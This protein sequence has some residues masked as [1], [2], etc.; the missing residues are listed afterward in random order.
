MSYPW[1]VEHPHDVLFWCPGYQGRL[2]W[3]ARQ[4]HDVTAGDVLTSSRNLTEIVCKQQRGAARRPDVCRR[5]ANVPPRVAALRRNARACSQRYLAADPK[6][7]PP[8]ESRRVDILHTLRTLQE[9]RKT[10][11]ALTILWLR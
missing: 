10:R 6:P 5:R 2:F 1:N 4:N 7:P 3:Q 8:P 9:R 11:E